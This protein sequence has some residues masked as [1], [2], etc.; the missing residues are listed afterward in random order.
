MYDQGPRQRH[1]RPT[2][3]KRSFPLHETE[4][5]SHGSSFSWLIM[6]NEDFSTSD[7]S[8]ASFDG[9][10]STPFSTHSNP[11]PDQHLVPESEMHGESGCWTPREGSTSEIVLFREGSPRLGNYTFDG[12]SSFS[13]HP[14]LRFASIPRGLQIPLS[15]LDPELLRVS[16][17]AL[18]E[19]DLS[20]YVVSPKPSYHNHT[21]CGLTVVRSVV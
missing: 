6:T 11:P 7:R 19:L 3:T 1:G 18:P 13:I 16:D 9:S 8:L 17:A 4:P 21:L 14:S 12:M 15:F 20:L 5:G 10:T 2:G